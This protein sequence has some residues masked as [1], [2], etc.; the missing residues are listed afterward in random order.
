MWYSCK[1]VRETSKV[2]WS[3][4]DIY[5][6]NNMDSSVRRNVWYEIL[7]EHKS[8]NE[9]GNSPDSWNILND[10]HL[11]QVAFPE[12]WMILVV[13]WFLCPFGSRLYKLGSCAGFPVQLCKCS[14][15]QADVT[16]LY[17]PMSSFARSL[18]LRHRFQVVVT[19]SVF[20]YFLFVG[21]IWV[22][23][24]VISKAPE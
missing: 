11:W 9:E 16:Y 19:K 18:Y 4:T 14:V 17:P 3:N 6:L 10:V 2:D 21:Q 20:P 5:E 7:V 1:A 8:T 22:I 15:V 12:S 23:S 24:V 13:V